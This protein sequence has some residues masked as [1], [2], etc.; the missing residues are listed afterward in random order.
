MP[1]FTNS[2][3][4][5][6]YY[7]F[8]SFDKRDTSSYFIG[9]GSDGGNSAYLQGLD[10][11][12]NDMYWT[13]QGSMADF[14]L[15]TKDHKY[16]TFDK[17]LFYTTLD[18]TKASHFKATYNTTTQRYDVQPVGGTNL[19]NYIDGTWYLAASGSGNNI[20]LIQTT[21]NR[22]YVLFTPAQVFNG[23]DY[24]DHAIRPKRSWFVKQASES[25][26]TIPTGFIQS[27]ESGFDTNAYSGEV[28]QK[29][30]TY[31]VTHYL[32]AGTN[33]TLVLPSCLYSGNGSDTRQRGY[34]RWYN[35]TTGE[36]VSNDLILFTAQSIRKYS[37]GLVMGT[38]LNFNNAYG[39]Y[40]GKDFIFQMPEEIDD[41][42][43]YVLGMDASTF[44]DFVDYFG[45]NGNMQYTG[46]TLNENVV[47]EHQDLIE[48]TLSSRNIFI[49]RNAR[50]IAN[51]L[52]NCKEGSDQWYEQHTIHFPKKKITL[53]RS[54]FSLNMQFQDYWYY[55]AATASEENLQNNVNSG[56]MVIEVDDN[57]S[58][59]TS[60]GPLAATTIGARRFIAFNYPGDTDGT[61]TGTATSNQCV[62]KIYGKASDGTRYQVAKVTLIFD[63]DAEPLVFSDVIGTNDDGTFKT[64]RSPEALE[65]NVG[66]P[67][68]SIDFNPTTYDDF[69]TPPVGKNY[70]FDTTTQNA[71]TSNPLTYRYPLL[72]E[73]SNYA[74]APIAGDFNSTGQVNENTWGS[75][76][77]THRFQNGDGGGMIRANNVSITKLYENIYG[78]DKYDASNSAFLYIDASD[79]PG[80]IASLDFEGTP[81][82]ASRLFVSAWIYC[83]NDRAG[84][85]SPAQVLFNVVG[86]NA[87]GKETI[88]YSFCPG[89]IYNSARN[90][91]GTELKPTEADRTPLWQQ[92]YFSFINSS[93]ESFVSYKLN[94]EN[95]CTN[96]AGGDIL[97]DNVK[98]FS[99]NATVQLE[100]TTPV[101]D[102][103]IT[104]TKMSTDF[105]A[106]L[107][108]LGLE[109]D[110]D[111][112][113]GRPLMWY[114]VLDKEIFDAEM[115]SL[116]AVNGTTL[117]KEQVKRAM[118]KAIIGDPSSTD[119]YRCAFRNVEFT[120][121]YTDDT[122]L[123][124]FNYQDA[125]AVSTATRFKE[126]TSDGVRHFVV[127]DKMQGSG[128]KANRLYYLLFTPRYS[129][130]PINTSN[131]V[132]A[133]NLD[134]DCR[135]MSYFKTA[136][137]IS[138]IQDGDG[139][140]SVDGA[141]QACAG[142]SV[143][144]SVKL[145]GS[146]SATGEEPQLIFC[147]DWWRDYVGG[148]FENIVMSSTDGSVRELSA[149]ETAAA[150]E[151]SLREALQNFRHFYPNAST[152]VGATPQSDEAYTLKQFVIDGL[153]KLTQNTSSQIAP[154]SLL[155]T[156]CNVYVPSTTPQG[157]ELVV[158]LIPVDNLETTGVQ[159]CF[160]PQH[161]T[162]QVHGLAPGLYNGL[163]AEGYVYPD[164]LTCVPI[165]SSL[166]A[167]T[168]V[169][170]ATA[171]TAP[172]TR[173]R[174]PLRGI[175]TITDGAT[176]L[177][178]VSLS[179]D[180]TAPL[181]LAGT[182]D[183]T[184]REK[185]YD[186]DADG[187]ITGLHQVGTVTALEA[188]TDDAA[189]AHADFYFDAD[190]T[191]REGYTYDLRI[192]FKERFADSSTTESTT[193]DGSLLADLNIVPAY[194][195]WTGA[196]GNN[197]W[198]CDLNWARADH[199]DLKRSPNDASYTSNATN[200]TAQ[201]F[202][203]MIHTS[204]VL[205]SGISYYP[206]IYQTGIDAT[207][208][209]VDFTDH[210]D[211]AR[212]ATTDIEY[213]LLT[214]P[215]ADATT[216]INECKIYT[217]Y[218][219]NDLV[220]APA[221]EVAG[222][223]LLSYSKA[224]M[225][226]S[227]NP[228]RWY[229]LGSPLQSTYAGDWYA[230]T[231]NGQQQSAYFADITFNTTSYNRFKPAVYQRSWDVAEAKLYYLE[232]YS[233]TAPQE[234]AVKD[235]NVYV[236]ATWSKVY[237]NVQVPY[238]NG[239]FSVKVNGT[240]YDGTTYTATRFR[241][242]KEDEQYSYYTEANATDGKLYA[243]DR[244]N[245]HRLLTD[246]MATTGQL[247]LTLHN[248][249]ANNAYYLV[250]NPF[251]CGLDMAKF[252]DENAAVLD[253]RKYWLLT[254]QGQTGVMQND[255]DAGWTTINST[256]AATANGILAPGQGFF[257]K[258]ATA[259]GLLALTFTPE[260]M[261]QAKA[262]N[263]LLRAPSRKGRSATTQA[264]PTLR[265]RA[266]RNGE[267][268]E[269]LVLKTDSA[270]NAY[271]TAEDMETLVDNSQLSAPTVYTLAGNT[272]SCI[273]RRRTM[274]RIP[275]G[276]LSDSEKPVSLTFSGMHTFS[277]TL[278]LLDA[279]N[280]SITPLS[281]GSTPEA[282]S[283]T[284]EVPGVTTGRYYILTSDTTPDPED[285]VTDSALLIQVV[286]QKAVI[287]S[288]TAH[289]LTYVHIV[290]A[291]GRTLYTMSPYT[292]E[293]SLKLAPGLYVVEANTD[294]QRS[295]AKITVQ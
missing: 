287:S 37:N 11:H 134:N 129:S 126:T 222:T 277:E 173:L 220:L 255:D 90:S 181:Y 252:F 87:A 238:S 170:E 136:S 7:V 192:D 172:A 201:G 268:T 49:L 164:H 243:V 279:S 63:E 9:G 210:E 295:V 165:R 52:L 262:V 112:S 207:D 46:G 203:P 197:E 18:A 211:D 30:N 204:L 168:E 109:E 284:I 294:T 176:G 96:T 217:P 8:I 121:H 166:A 94:I 16:L 3:S 246:N 123:P 265:I 177:K 113:F 293:L 258:A 156:T 12:L 241:L 139:Q 41:N 40:V 119:P 50:T 225:E 260:M 29:A 111:P 157:Q 39:T 266:T 80:R 140:L 135:M 66:S 20:T 214:N 234:T 138:V 193:C 65:K 257:V 230:P 242:P 128:L 117:D 191:P 212:T 100:H 68:A 85:E 189:N 167:I 19:D 23:E 144:L 213:A 32:K 56:G 72:F 102:Q 104:L 13:L 27:T 45:D 133:F 73:N 209:F 118:L 86:V 290:D 227:L 145:N 61:G 105:D 120:T 148:T 142:K 48:P 208:H 75:Y 237:N 244:T 158:T 278:S 270:S 25:S 101:C 159:Y 228:D 233:A 146:D 163:S 60:A 110:E 206:T 273:N 125:L 84:N 150:G 122:Q 155:N 249:V 171:G 14:T 236:G 28:E 79:L 215:A 281:L 76:S 153:Y 235:R 219:A 205:P 6:P 114:C 289:P 178:M 5:E 127:S 185:V 151:I 83:A 248:T 59:I 34:Q 55:K 31:T 259:T 77:I 179:D 51:E 190:F 184:M 264:Q 130:E 149:G 71:S 103:Q 195:V 17:G 88:L 44:T 198:T 285:E 216:H 226:Y 221:A 229:T 196:A 43:E 4:D 141:T 54:S 160:D 199:A 58:G 115:T 36:P 98:V 247:N 107:Q 124:T 253:G 240:S 162:L 106:I 137:A 261:A 2:E 282:D 53:G 154:L 169:T 218:T 74:F 254:A 47:P 67:V 93:S 263:S 232:P 38:E 194:Q 62:F 245:A 33:R 291:E 15:R 116:S 200:G 57:G 10:Q 231:D 286:G 250:G 161:I 97:I 69:I 108:Q 35:Y 183:P 82:S 24:T 188:L 186:I 143:S 180:G 256:T 182:N 269:A 42:Y 22:R 26:S 239:G 271:L 92:V 224:W 21:E 132:D 187:N 283:V 272:V 64:N 175:K 288:P 99:F 223:H 202:A 174:M 251:T 274:Q 70:S 276:V 147:Y 267:T 280:G 131:A 1:P 78:S 89:S 95:A 91:A 152:T 292:A 81:C 275:V